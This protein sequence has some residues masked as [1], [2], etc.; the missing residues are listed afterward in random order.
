MKPVI[1]LM[2]ATTLVANTALAAAWPP[3]VNTPPF[4]SIEESTNAAWLE[5]IA[6]SLTNAQQLGPRGGLG[7]SAKDLRTA[8]YA[9][10]GALA[11]P[12]SLAA[13]QRIE[14]QARGQP[15]APR[16]V[17]IGVWTHPGWHF[18]DWE[19]VRLAQTKASDG[20][21]YAVLVSSLLGS[22]DLFLIS[23][24]TPDDPA[25]WSRPV[26]VSKHGQVFL[27]IQQP[28]LKVVNEDL[29]ELTYF[30]DP[31]L[32][33]DFIERY[34]ARGTTTP[35]PG[36]QRL[37]I[38]LSD[39]LRDTDRDGWTDLEEQRLGLDPNKADTDGDGL[40]DG[41]D[42]CPNYAPPKAAATNE[43]AQILQKAVFATFG[44]SGAR[45]LLIVQ[46]NSP[47]VQ[48]LGY[49]GPIIF[50][51]DSVSDWWARHGAGGIFVS[52][53]VTRMGDEAEVRLSDYVGPEAG[54]TQGIHLKKIR[55]QWFVVRR[56]F[57]KVS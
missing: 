54:G 11:T 7:G 23:T 9:R 42:P 21:T 37:E 39:V 29:L 35:K 3:S 2:F 38:R 1:G 15:I 20:R 17:P 28:R 34:Q 57:G 49:A 55:G 5:S 14:Q 43:D 25:S 30:H 24:T 13:V 52:W 22:D 56:Q 8:A 12:A 41:M 53:D 48:I 10:L 19:V 33:P 51:Q 18:G 47:K 27:N 4:L 32:P 46:T 44:L 31:P 16:S 45:H 50:Q 40:A 36:E 6:Q 26:L